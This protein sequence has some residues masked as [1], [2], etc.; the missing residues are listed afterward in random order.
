MCNKI[1][2]LSPSYI[3]KKPKETQSD[4]R[5]QDLGGC[6]ASLVEGNE[7]SCPDNIAVAASLGTSGR[8]WRVVSSLLSPAA[9]TKEEDER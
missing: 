7:R 3:A 8:H 4:K 9:K 6:Q 2:A 5:P 1:P